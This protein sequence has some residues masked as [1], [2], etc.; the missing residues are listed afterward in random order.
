MIFNEIK[1]VGPFG[2]A[3]IKHE[4]YLW[5]LDLEKFKSVLSYDYLLLIDKAGFT[6]Y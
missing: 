4:I 6:E 2:S 1:P 5:F 3:Q